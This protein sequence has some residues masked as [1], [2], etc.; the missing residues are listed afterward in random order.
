MEL[1]YFDI[2]DGLT[3]RVDHTGHH[4]PDVD[5]ARKAATRE[6]TLMFKDDI[7]NGERRGYVVT[8]CD[9]KGIPIYVA[10]ATLLC[11]T[12]ERA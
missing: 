6:L 11:E 3:R 2:S 12:L 9:A 7:P 4:Y 10:T 5:S 8:L 1:F